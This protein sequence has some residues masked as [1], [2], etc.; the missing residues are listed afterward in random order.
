MENRQII[1]VFGNQLEVG[2]RIGN[3]FKTYL[4]D[5]LNLGL[6][7][8][9]RETVVYVAGGTTVEGRM[10]EADAGAEYLR[11][12]WERGAT[13]ALSTHK[14]FLVHAETD[15]HTTKE[16]VRNTVRLIVAHGQ[17]AGRLVLVGRTAQLLRARAYLLRYRKLLNGIDIGNI[18]HLNSVNSDPIHIQAAE[19]CVFLPL[20]WL[21]LDDWVLGL[22][23]KLL[24]NG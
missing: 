5:A 14:S 4:H 22:I 17:G 18:V 20:A 2:D 1:I 11:A 9:Y 19:W 10:A 3:T 13:Y 24:R 7:G 8:E 6:L 12:Q 23:K 15:S 16:N 21:G